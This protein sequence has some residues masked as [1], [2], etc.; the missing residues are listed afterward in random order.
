M[1]VVPSAPAAT[2]GVSTTADES[3]PVTNGNCTLREA[4]QAASTN[5]TPSV[6]LCVNGDAGALDTIELETGTYSLTGA[7]GDNAN[8]S[9]DLDIN[10]RAGTEGPLRIDGIAPDVT[11]DGASDDR[12][13]HHLSG[14]LELSDLTVT[15]GG[16][17]ATNEGQG[18]LS[19]GSHL[20]LTSAAVTQNSS[21]LGTGTSGGG[22]R[23]A[24]AS[25]GTLTI[26]D[27]RITENGTNR[28][29]GG[30]S[31]SNG[32]LELTGSVVADNTV[33]N[34]NSGSTTGGGGIYMSEPGAASI[35]SSSI[36]GNTVE[37][38][39]TGVAR[40]TGGGIYFDGPAASSVRDSTISGNQVVENQP[41]ALAPAGGGI[42]H[43]HN[44]GG[45]TQIRVVNSTL[46]SN[47]VVGDADTNEFLF[48]GGAYWA[49]PSAAITDRIVHSTLAEN[50]SPRGDAIASF[51]FVN[52]GIT[53]QNSI[54]DDQ[55]GVV[56]D[57]CQGTPLVSAGRNVAMG[58]TC[59][60]GSNATD[61]ESTDPDLLPLGAFGGPTDTSPPE[62]GSPAVDLVP[63]Q[64]CNDGAPVPALLSEDQRDFPRPF[65]GDGNSSAR[66]DAG[67]VEVIP[68]AGRNATRIG[69]PGSDVMRGT[70][71]ADVMMG[72]EGDDRVK[73]TDGSDRLCGFDGEDLLV[74]GA[75]KDTLVGQRGKDRC[76]GSGGRDKAQGCEKKSGIP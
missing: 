56:S 71:G 33:S 55:D 51:A 12:V 65:D 30:I 9:G 42:Y 48:G 69:T 27:S 61:R 38:I 46:A 52:S 14:E 31:V 24:P 22:I 50:S 7:N 20:T 74:G 19:T 6:D 62:V 18:I 16:L 21:P 70:P 37:V 40:P 58:T 26:T 59:V 60:N 8:Q 73:G 67:A 13:L 17:F 75:G 5:G 57:T 39:G 72:F 76:V 49:S 35:S 2:I 25:L 34:A 11:I 4:I 66:C 29:G 68:C 36:S 32:N 54:V 64:D 15:G 43:G 63:T 47:S 44:N 3:P 23:Y 41:D 10:A 53:L 45:G 28:T 1:L